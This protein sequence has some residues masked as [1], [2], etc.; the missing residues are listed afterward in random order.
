MTSE[1][2]GSP[3]T[4]TVIATITTHSLLGATYKTDQ[5]LEADTIEGLKS[6]MDGARNVGKGQGEETG[7]RVEVT[8]APIMK[9]NPETGGRTT[10]TE[11]QKKRG[12][13][14]RIFGHTSE[15][16]PSVL[17]EDK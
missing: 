1:K 17:P 12:W 5:L 11:I 7:K 14:A 15:V 10:F 2:P 13:L 6:Q 4:F 3:K 9:L 16:I 8:F